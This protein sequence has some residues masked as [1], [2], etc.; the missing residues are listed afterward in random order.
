MVGAFR[1]LPWLVSVVLRGLRPRLRGFATRTPF[2]VVSVRADVRVQLVFGQ[3]DD[4]QARCVRGKRGPRRLVIS[5]RRSA[6]LRASPSSLRS[7][8]SPPKGA[9]RVRRASGGT[10]APPLLW[11]LSA[12]LCRCVSCA[13][14][15]AGLRPGVRGK[16]GPR[17]LVIS[18]RRS[19]SLR[20]SPNSLRSPASP[21]KGAPC[22]LRSPASPRVEWR[23]GP[24]E[25]ANHHAPSHRR[26][27]ASRPQEDDSSRHGTD[28]DQRRDEAM[29][30]TR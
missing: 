7:P 27:V 20:A 23:G 5:L 14:R 26:G 16:R 2:V 15:S 3:I 30:R 21:P 6:S 24:A 17:R 19:A 28:R 22:S 12:R 9:P 29:S 8:A 1:R 10:P 11:L 13:V 18:L 25:N 4:A